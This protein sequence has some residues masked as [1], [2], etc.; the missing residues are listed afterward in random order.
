MLITSPVGISLLCNFIYWLS[1]LDPWSSV[2]GGSRQP[3]I[4]NTNAKLWEDPTDPAVPSSIYSWH[5]TLQ[6]IDKTA[7]WVH[8]DAPKMAYFFPHPALFVRGKSAEHKEQYLHNW[9]VSQSAWITHLLTCD[10]S[11]VPSHSWCDFLNLIPINFTST[12]SGQQLKATANLFRPSFIR[13]TCE[14]PLEVQFH[15][16]TLNLA[17]LGTLDKTT[18]G[19]ILWDLYEHNFQFE[20]VVLDCLLCPQIW[21]DP[22]NKWLNHIRQIQ[23]SVIYATV[24]TVSLFL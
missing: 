4:V 8:V 10:S 11:P 21:L 23:L 3:R 22:N 20:L 12:H 9:L 14:E 13:S 18:K 7:N 1:G 15:N 5:V 16:L 6:D 24:V 2:V 19:K 17:S